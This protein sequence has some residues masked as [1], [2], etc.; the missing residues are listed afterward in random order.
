MQAYGVVGAGVAVEHPSRKIHKH[1]VL[2]AHRGERR[3]EVVD[4]IRTING[5]AQVCRVGDAQPVPVKQSRRA[6][7]V[8]T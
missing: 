3:P 2:R 7:D 1:D 6:T 5:H 4:S 8:K